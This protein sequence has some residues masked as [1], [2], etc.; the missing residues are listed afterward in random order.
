MKGVYQR[1]ESKKIIIMIMRHV[2]GTREVPKGVKGVYM[3]KAIARR[4]EELKKAR[5]VC[6]KGK[7]SYI[8]FIRSNEKGGSLSDHFF[9][10]PC[11]CS[12]LQFLSFWCPQSLYFPVAFSLLFFF[13]YSLFLQC[14]Q[15]CLS[16]VALSLLFVFSCFPSSQCLQSYFSLQLIYCYFFIIATLS[17]QC[18]NSSF[19]LLLFHRCFFFHIL[20]HCSVFRAVVSSVGLSL[21]FVFILSLLLV[22]S[23][24]F[25]CPQLFFPV[26]LVLL[27]FFICFIF[28]VSSD[29]F[30]FLLLFSSCYFFHILPPSQHPQSCFIPVTRTLFPFLHRYDWNLWYRWSV[31]LERQMAAFKLVLQVIFCS[32]PGAQWKEWKDGVQ[33]RP[34]K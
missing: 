7:V 30:F 17:F 11:C 8:V 20:C 12:F 27:S 23:E 6:K 14:P 18:P 16:P 26:A 22:A 19:Y 9:P 2:Y 25:F 3:K 34:L 1:R 5:I 28:V 15:S 29:N 21:Q 31:G 10:L 32:P 24:M 33:A 4:S 13:I